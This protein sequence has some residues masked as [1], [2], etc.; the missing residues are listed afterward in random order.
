MILQSLLLSFLKK[1]F[2]NLILSSEHFNYF[3]NYHF[4]V[5]IDAERKI[6]VYQSSN[7]NHAQKV[8]ILTRCKQ[9]SIISELKNRKNL[10]KKKHV[11]QLNDFFPES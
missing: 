1:V 2:S 9:R 3:S 4:K 10:A 11:L 7:P 5:N 8:N 6:F